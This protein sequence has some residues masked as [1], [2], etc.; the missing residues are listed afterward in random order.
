MAG[1]DGGEQPAGLLDGDFWRLALAI[2]IAWPPDAGGG[3]E[4]HDMPQHQLVEE[5]LECRQ[6]LL[7]GRHTGVEL[8][9]ILADLAGTDAGE[10][11]ALASRP[12]EELPHGM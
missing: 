10:L 7:F 12:G 9:D 5:A 11:D 2:G 3:V 8:V 6:V 4:Q 1:I